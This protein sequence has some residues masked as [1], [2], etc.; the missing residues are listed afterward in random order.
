MVAQLCIL[1]EL[2]FNE[3]KI[4]DIYHSDKPKFNPAYMI[5]GFH[6]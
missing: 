5:L 4:I 3:N 6:L 1:S 2:G